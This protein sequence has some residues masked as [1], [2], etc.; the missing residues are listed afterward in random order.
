[1]YPEI[2]TVRFVV[3]L[4]ETTTRRLVLNGESKPLV[5]AGNKTKKTVLPQHQNIT[6]ATAI[7]LSGDPIPPRVCCSSAM[8]SQDER[9]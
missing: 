2:R 4:L 1:M 8:F 3:G 7:D 6:R 9:R 5:P